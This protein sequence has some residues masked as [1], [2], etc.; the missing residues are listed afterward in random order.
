[1]IIAIG[2]KRNFEYDERHVV[3]CVGVSIIGNFV[4]VDV[5]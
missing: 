4:K 3:S 1:M 2:H 5:G